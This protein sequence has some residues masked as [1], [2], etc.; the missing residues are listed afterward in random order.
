MGKVLSFASWNVEQFQGRG[1]RVGRVI[2]LLAEHD[3]DVFA[4][5]EVKGSDVF[6]GLMSGMPSHSFTITESTSPIEILVG[7][8]RNIP[9]FIT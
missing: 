7:V 3:P 4:I 5:L 1:E 8:R 2:G 6:S 9:S